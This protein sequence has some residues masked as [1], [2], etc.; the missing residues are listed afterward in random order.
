MNRHLTAIRHLNEATVRELL[1]R[2]AFYKQAC[3]EKKVKK[4]KEPK[5]LGLLFFEGSTRTRVSF[6][7]AAFY[8]G[9]HTTNFASQGSSMAKGET[10]RDTI[11]TLKHERIE[12][13]I[14]RHPASGSA[15]LAANIFGGPL[16]NAGDGKHEHPTQALG[17]ALTILEKKGSIEGLVVSIVGDVL[18]SRV[19]RSNA[20][21]LN[22]LGAEVR[23]VGP[24]TLMPI[25]AGRLPGKVFYDLEPGIRGADVVMCLR[26]QRERMDDGLLTSVTEFRKAYQ[27]NPY[28]LR[29]AAKDAILMHPGPMNRGVELDDAVADGPQ[30]V[31]L[32]QV[33]NCVFARMAAL[34]WILAGGAE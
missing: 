6:E 17:D 13:M 29:R 3:L 4:V 7:Q 1:D 8:L 23:F 33:E 28:T 31:I 19:A 24:R 20:W 9:H 25:H 34:E 15:A 12:A 2:A 30:S 26:L 10:L 11:L 16:I 22:S 14:I 18:H 27:I 21:L 32:N 5:S